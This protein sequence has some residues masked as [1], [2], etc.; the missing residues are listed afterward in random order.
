M[1]R[2]GDKE[3]G[4][5]ERGEGRIFLSFFLRVPASPRPFPPAL[6]PPAPRTLHPIPTR[7]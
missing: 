6:L 2:W 4:D 7:C 1:G 5:T 3:R